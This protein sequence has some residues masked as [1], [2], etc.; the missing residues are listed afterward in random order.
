LGSHVCRMLVGSRCRV[1]VFDNLSLGRRERLTSL[2]SQ[3]D[4]IHADV[5]N[6]TALER[7][8]VGTDAIVHLAGTPSV[9]DPIRA[10]EVNLRGTLNVLEAAH[11]RDRRDRPRVILCSAGNVYGRQPAFVLHEELMPRPLSPDAVIALTIESFGRLYNEIYGVP[12]MSLRLFRVFGPE[13]EPERPDS[14]VVA[15]FVRAALSG[16]SPVI[17][18]D[19]QQTRDLIYVDNA[20]AAIV[21]ALQSELTSDPLNV[22]SGEAVAINF[23]WT[24]VLET[25]GKRRLAIDPTYLPAPSWEVRHARPQIARACKT[26]GWAPTVRL[27]EALLRTVNFLRSQASED[28]YAWFSPHDGAREKTSVRQEARTPQVLAFPNKALETDVV[29]VSEA[30]LVEDQGGYEHDLERSP[31]PT[32]PGMRSS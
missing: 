27:R 28:P 18:G 14:S 11:R 24:L 2:G 9:G 10:E 7:A 25:C 17:F 21:A 19:G 26:L 13:E 31:V 6:E 4:F 15:K 22:A 23:L 8:V 30:D 1:R 32:I 29:E 5:R 12:V 20:A 16:N 3:I